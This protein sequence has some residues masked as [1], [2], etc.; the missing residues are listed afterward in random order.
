MLI[1]KTLGFACNVHDLSKP[2][3]SQD[4]YKLVR[5]HYFT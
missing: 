3:T 5:H 2:I 4:F 1:Q